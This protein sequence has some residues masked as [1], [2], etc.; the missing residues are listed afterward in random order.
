MIFKDVVADS[1]DLDFCNGSIKNSKFI[2][3]GNDAI[4]FSGSEVEVENIFANNVKDKVISAGEKSSLNINNLDAQN[5]EI[6]IAS[7]DSSVVRI[8]NISSKN[9]KHIFAA[10]NKKPEFNGGIIYTDKRT[11]NNYSILKDK[12]SKIIIGSY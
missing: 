1:I 8:K 2:D 12:E 11:I 9:N 7:K 5:S 10:Y 3:I 4:D 6:V